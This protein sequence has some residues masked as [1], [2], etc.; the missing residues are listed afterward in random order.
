MGDTTSL[1]KLGTAVRVRR[2]AAGWTQ[3][4][5]AV[6]AGVSVRLVQNVEQ[7]VCARPR[8]AALRRLA[9]ALGISPTERA[10]LTLPVTDAGPPADAEPLRVEL[11][12]PLRVTCDQ[13]P[14]DV[15]GDRCRAVL[16]LVALQAGQV[17]SLGTLTAEL[18]EG[19]PPPTAQAM[20]QAQVRRLRAAVAGKTAG[21][22]SRTLVESIAGGYR[23]CLA[24]TSLDILEFRWHAQ[25]AREARRD[26]DMRGA[27]EA[28]EAG[29]ALWRGVPL[30]DVA[31]LRG[32]PAVVTLSGEHTRLVLV[33]AE[34][35]FA[36]GRHNQVVPA[37]FSL[38]ERHPLDEPVH[39]ALMIA[40]AGTGRQAAALEV[41]EQVRL[42]LDEQLGVLPGALL[43][44]AH[45]RVLRQEVAVGSA[46]QGDPAPS[47][48]APA[49]NGHP[50]PGGPSR[51]GTGPAGL[52]PPCQLPPAAR[53]FTGRTAEEARVREWLVP[54]A[55]SGT[56][57]VVI[58]SGL[59]GAG[60]TT[61]ALQAA[62][63]VRAGFPDGQ[64]W[65]SLDGASSRP[66]DP[67]EVLGEWL[68]ALGVAGA[69]IPEKTGER[70]ALFRSRLAG[71]RV[72][73]VVDDAGSAAQLAPL[74]PGTG[75]SAVLV[76]SRRQLP[77]VAGAL[78][79][80]LGPMDSVEGHDLLSR[81]AG[82]G[83][84]AAEPR[85]AAD[86]VA[87]CGRLPLAIR[88]AGA[89]LAARPT[90][91][92]EGLA[93]SLTQEQQWLAGRAGPGGRRPPDTQRLN[94]LHVGD[95][96]VRASIA[97][98]YQALSLPSQRAF[99][100][101]G[102]LGPCDV[103]EWVI[104]A[105]LGHPADGVADELTDRSML[106]VVG[107]D[108]TRQLRYR[109]HDLLRDY[110]AE[111]AATL[112]IK[113][114]H[115][116]VIH[117]LDG[118]L[119]LAAQA[120]DQLQWPVF[121]QYRPAVLPEVVPRPLAERLVS[122]P[123]AWFQAERENL[124][125]ITE[126]CAALGRY[127]FAAELA[128]C[129]AEAQRLQDR[130]HDALRMWRAVA[131]AAEAA[132]DQLVVARAHMQLASAAAETGTAVETVRILLDQCVT[133][134]EQHDDPEGLT[135]TLFWLGQ[136]EWMLERFDAAR[137]AA[138]RGVDLA[139]RTG[140]RRAHLANL[141][142]LGMTLASTGDYEA[143]V[144]AC[145]RS[146]GLAMEMNGRT[147]EIALHFLAL[148]CV[149]AGRYERAVEV[150]SARRDICTE[151]GEAT[152]VAL[153]WGVSGDACYGLGRYEDALAAYHQALPVFRDW[154]LLPSHALCLYKLGCAHHALHSYS[155][156]AHYLTESLPMFHD[157]GLAGYV[158]R[159][160]AGLRAC[161]E[162]STGPPVLP[163][164][165]SK[166]TS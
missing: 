78:F 72:L 75:G 64:L 12:G 8:D 147:H 40:L 93:S 49:D 122:Q 26:G 98:G 33:Q 5:L 61:L 143:G 95:L 112:G 118:W 62:H 58:V 77:E 100:L 50:G 76:T 117:A 85:A 166:Q 3:R 88:I 30:S 80:P 37:L 36:L 20:V 155:E 159:A 120:S 56:V 101:L 55:G 73:V 44:D 31:L 149:L 38:A 165:A 137:S 18:W 94:V 2:Q 140:N 99:R 108:E 163:I 87:A 86:L 136:T 14:L 114:H 84:V 16:A 160:E 146:A 25:Q 6:E 115:A 142:T 42:H 127:R 60:K 22:P 59:P 162:P 39:A 52:E 154:A 138:E 48:T 65:A 83:R 23:L 133:T 164:N 148:A 92:L 66:R 53:D 11:L 161:R 71:R 91:P 156:A 89:K 111:Q 125:T 116:A 104:A 68:R 67:G 35:A 139:Q 32:H 152:G 102:L 129:Q 96:S 107:T 157:L 145:E 135:F 121:P 144:A 119:Q 29:L 46:G 113:E 45:V 158:Q 105:L 132:G 81:I 7:G 57:P 131:S 63:L 19:D 124:L 90:M 17:V 82:S 43:A 126:Q 41:F 27:A 153:S 79:L 128:H 9:D 4:R 97:S 51:A 28:A 15:T 54:A 69:S 13:R 134:F 141:Q 130:H 106:S 21:E 24:R 110:A 1:T 103:A 109:L 47:A 74:L 70:A 150:C 34:A 10:A 151:M 123:L